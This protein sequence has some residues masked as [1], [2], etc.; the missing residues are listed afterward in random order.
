M[1]P[2]IRTLPLRSPMSSAEAARIGMSST[3]GLPR[4]VMTMHSS[5]T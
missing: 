1:S 4:L 3:T 2:P 5:S